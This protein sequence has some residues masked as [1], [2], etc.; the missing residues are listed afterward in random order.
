MMSV[1]EVRERGWKNAGEVAR[2]VRKDVFESDDFL[3]GVAAF[4]EKRKP[5]GR[6]SGMRL[7]TYLVLLEAPI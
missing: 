5:S 6:R 3:E 4:R 2:M 1:Q 7:T